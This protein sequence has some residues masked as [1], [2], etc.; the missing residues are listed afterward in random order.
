MSWNIK[1]G[2]V[3]VL[4]ILLTACESL[5]YYSQA[6]NGQ[7]YIFSHRKPIARML[8]D[9]QTSPA[10]KARL[11]SINRIRTFAATE[12]HLPLGSQYSTYLDLKRPFVVWNVFAAPEFSMQPITWCYP[13][14]GCVSYRGYFNESAARDFAAGLQDEGNDVY[15]GGVAAY[16]TLGWFSDPVLSTIINRDEYQLASLIFHE[17]A[18]QVIYIPDETEFN[19]S[20]A[21]TVEREG[22]QRWLQNDASEPSVKAQLTQEIQEER[23][24]QEQFVALVQTAVADLNVLYAGSLAEPAKRLA[25][26]ERIAKLRADYAAL[27]IQWQGYSGYDAW[28]A[29]DLNN[30]QLGT[31]VTYNT[32]VPAFTAMLRQAHGD[33]LQFYQNAAQLKQLDRDQRQQQLRMLMA[34]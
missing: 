27:K 13:I 5:Q 9:S 26:Q 29:R 8:E 3:C 17:L 1:I 23:V 18:H 15:V 20:F 19:E 25:K 16:S 10:L 6:V 22:L 24:R 31:V 34:P 33:F 30:A 7:L 14:A 28:F 2:F 12:L 32:Y 21:T 11:E 4:C